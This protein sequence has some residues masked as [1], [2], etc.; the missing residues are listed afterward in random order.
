MCE[1]ILHNLCLV[2]LGIGNCIVN[3]RNFS[4]ISCHYSLHANDFSSFSV[5]T[6]VDICKYPLEGSENFLQ[7]RVTVIE[8][9]LGCSAQMIASVLSLQPEALSCS[10]WV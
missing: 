9:G 7:W 3:Y 10:C 6:N 8:H 2:F 4:S 1:V 5:V